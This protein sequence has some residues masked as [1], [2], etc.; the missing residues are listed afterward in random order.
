MYSYRGAKRFLVES[1]AKKTRMRQR[2]VIT[3]TLGELIA[4]VTDEVIPTIHSHS[5]LYTV[6]VL[7]SC[8]SVRSQSDPRPQRLTAKTPSL[9]RSKSNA[10][11][12]RDL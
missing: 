3:T 7:G 4:A 6:R 1:D 11:E 9:F 2:K 8:R 5:R 10:D 12:L